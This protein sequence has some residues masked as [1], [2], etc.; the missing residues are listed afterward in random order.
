MEP[1][2]TKTE[3]EPKQQKD[4]KRQRGYSIHEEEDYRK[5]WRIFRVMAEFVEGYE[6]LSSVENQVTVLGSARTKEDGK[7]YEIARN[8]G[9]LLGE[10]NYSTVTGGGPGIMEAANRGAYEVDGESI[11]L[12]IQLPFEQRVN[13]YVKKAIGFSFFSTRKVM[14]TTPANAFV[15]FPGGFGTMDEFFEIID[16]IE[17]DKMCEAPI[18]LVGSEYW[19]PLLDFLKNSGCSLGS[20]SEEQIKKWHVV[21]NA[22]QAF[23]VIQQEGRAG[24]ETC[25]LSPTHFHT[26]TNMNWRVFRIMSELVDGFDFVNDLQD[27]I[28]VF[29]TK[30]IKEDSIYYDSGYKL[31][32]KLAKSGFT[33]ITGGAPG[34]DEAVNKGSSDAGGD[35]VGIGMKVRGETRLNDYVNR[36]LI[37]D[38]PFTR[39]MVVTAPSGGFVF[40]PGG[41]GTLHQL[42]EVLTLIQT[43]KMDQV[44]IILYD[45][46]FWE[47]WHV[48]I[49][50]N[51]HHRYETI[52][53]TDDELYQIVDDED[54]ILELI[55]NGI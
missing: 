14:L 39:K 8:L 55:N 43:N 23:D 18:V 24:H 54:T 34:I 19:Q 50:K 10:N 27:D 31:G 41:F 1:Q 5:P 53:D 49:K 47:P 46:D 2:T 45:H 11:G 32:Q 6:L 52:S 42:F 21:E 44:P 28:S 40:Y 4:M 29:G 13:D 9:K 26:E 7:Y 17:L 51:L 12:N 3:F 37:F 48:F 22:Q 35:S 36:S 25:E 33:P 20:I 16:H 38:F 30:S 15:L